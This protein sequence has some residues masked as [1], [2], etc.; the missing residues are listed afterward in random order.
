MSYLRQ[1]MYVAGVDLEGGHG[2]A[3]ATLVLDDLIQKYI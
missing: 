1:V 3:A 2:E